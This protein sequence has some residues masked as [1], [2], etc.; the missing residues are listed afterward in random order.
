M[1]HLV[2]LLV[3]VVFLT[4]SC[5]TKNG[6][7]F[8]IHM[9]TTKYNGTIYKHMCEYAHTPWPVYMYVHVQSLL[10]FTRLTLL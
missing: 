3:A 1:D 4:D 2:V 9:Y 5:R 7:H 8:V 10:K 6:L